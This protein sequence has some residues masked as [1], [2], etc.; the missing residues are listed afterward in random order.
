MT[1][2]DLTGLTGIRS[3]DLATP[4]LFNDRF[5]TLSRNLDQLNTDAS[6]VS[7]S[8]ESALQ[9]MSELS[10][11]VSDLRSDVTAS[12]ASIDAL[13][14]G[15]A[16]TGHTHNAGDVT[17]GTFADARISASAV[18]Q[19]EGA[20]TIQEGQIPDG[21]TLARLAAD[22]SVSGSWTF[23]SDVTAEGKIEGTNAFLDM[24]NSH[25]V[26]EAKSAGVDFRFR[27]AGGN[28]IIRVHEEGATVALKDAS[29][30]GPTSDGAVRN[31]IHH[32]SGSASAVGVDGT[33]HTEDL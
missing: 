24:I 19:H 8:A 12:N 32:G 26:W 6:A 10:S 20:L 18:T 31:I 11:D 25:S 4:Q 28:D 27:D 23:T 7:A 22:E 15:K 2:S 21:S 33:L 5:S 16:D 3:G 29:N 1:L 30:A 17:S 14:S 9:R 13:Q